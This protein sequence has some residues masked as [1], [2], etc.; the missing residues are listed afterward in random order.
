M[1]SSLP[2]LAEDFAADT[3]ARGLGTREHALGRGDDGEA[4]SAQDRG[5]LFLAA[6]DATARAR[7]ALD[8]V[9]DRLAVLRV[10]EVDAQRALGLAVVAH[11]FEVRNETLGL[12]D[13]RQDRK[14]TRLNSSH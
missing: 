8:A 11:L 10:L 6:I 12:E 7:N 2:D 1:C 4:E 5:D 9:N 3:L 13:A 14:S